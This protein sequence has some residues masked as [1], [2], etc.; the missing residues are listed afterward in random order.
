M[1]LHGFIFSLIMALLYFAHLRR[2]RVHQQAK[3]RQQLRRQRNA[4]LAV[5]WFSPACRKCRRGWIRGCYLK[6]STSCV[7]YT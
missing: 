5:A 3:A 1:H 2:S 4:T 6:C 7:A